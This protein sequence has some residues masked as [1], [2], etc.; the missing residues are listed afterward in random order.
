[1][2]AFFHDLRHAA[3]ALRGARG[4]AA[5]GV[6]ALALG[7]GTATAAFAAGAPPGGLAG[8]AAVF[9]AACAGVG[10]LLAARAAERRGEVALRLAL[11]ATPGGLARQMLAEGL[12]LAAA[13]GALGTLGAMWAP[14]P[15]GFGLPAAAFAAGATL[16]AGCLVGAAPALAASRAARRIRGV[17]RYAVSRRARETGVRLALGADGR[18]L[19]RLAARRGVRPAALAVALAL[20]AGAGARLAGPALAAAVGAALLLGALAT[21][22]AARRAARVDPAVAFRGD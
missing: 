10:C 19:A 4:A 21:W 1:M 9:L 2:R 8:A 22:L 15:A 18:D 16:A 6:G 20:A 11:G 17:A 12:V 5:A 13:G 3:R 14:G 7:T